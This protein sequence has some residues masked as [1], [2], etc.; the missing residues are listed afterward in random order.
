MK[1]VLNIVAWKIEHEHKV[2][3]Y[4][5]YEKTR[6]TLAHTHIKKQLL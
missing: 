6:N 4:Q 2:K 1:Y 3:K 5:K